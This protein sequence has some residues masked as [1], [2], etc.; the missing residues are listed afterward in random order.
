MT[1]TVT[2][3]VIN[4]RN[5][6]EAPFDGMVFTSTSDLD[7]YITE[8]NPD[9]VTR[10]AGMK[11]SLDE[12]GTITE[13]VLSSDR[14]T[15]ETAGG[16][17]TTVLLADIDV[18][19]VDQGN[20]ES[21]DNIPAG[22]GFEEIF[23]NMLKKTIPPT[24]TPPTV[25]LGGSGTLSVESGTLVSP[26]LTPNFNQNDAGLT[27]NYELFRQALSIFI[28]GT[29]IAHAD[30]PFN[31]GDENIIYNAELDYADGPIKND[32]T[33]T[34]DATGRILAGQI[35]SNN[36][37]YRGQRKLFYGIDGSPTAIR[38]NPLNYL[39]PS[40]GT[41]RSFSGSGGSVIFSYPDTLRDMTQASLTSSGFT[42]DILSEF[43]RVADQLVDDANAGNPINYKVFEYNP[44]GAFTSADFVLTI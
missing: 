32:N 35:T 31:I 25:S 2:M 13:Y 43:T 28:N 39:N 30:T 26:T 1:T 23:N 27:T 3:P 22:T 8:V 33:G 9:G 24:Y 41:S 42:F 14:L 6:A 17:G 4:K 12:G 18:L 19:D 20:Y 36:V 5:Y 40:N 16:G 21:G 15:W 44:A 34:P 11:V 7:D 38:T 37:T 29:A 10:Y